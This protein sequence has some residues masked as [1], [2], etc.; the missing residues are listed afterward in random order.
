MNQSELKKEFPDNV[1]PA[2][3]PQQRMFSTKQ[4][5]GAYKYTVVGN[6]GWLHF[7]TFELYTLFLSQLPSIAGI[8]LRRLCLA[9]FF[10]NCGK[11][12]VVGTGVTFRAPSYISLGRG[13]VIDDYA[14]VDVRPK[15]DLTIPPAVD[16]GDSVYI[17]RNSIVSAKYG[18]ISLG[19]GVNIG[20]HCRIATQTTLEIGNSVLI[21][22]YVYIGGGNHRSSSL[23][24]PLMEQGMDL[25]GGVKIG[26]NSWIGTK[27]TIVDGVTIGRDVIVGAHSLVR[28]DVPDRAIVAGVPANIIRYRE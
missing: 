7:T 13:V 1:T 12:L 4:S 14:L 23:D 15:E 10:R 19:S 22:A 16:I 18:R 26:A 20:S 24:V 6:K 17:G 9:P 8:A 27:S 3:T 21:A 2:M 25:R 11:G 28:Q 5:L